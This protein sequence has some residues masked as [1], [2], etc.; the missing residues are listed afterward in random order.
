MG[1]EHLLEVVGMGVGGGDGAGADLDLDGAVAA[2][3]LDEFRA[4]D[5][6]WPGLQV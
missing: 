1:F 3:G 2:G 6:R 5:G 4:C